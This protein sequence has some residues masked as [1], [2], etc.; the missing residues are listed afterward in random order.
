[1]G[2]N[3]FRLAGSYFVNLSL[4]KRTRLVGAQI[5]EFRA[6]ATNVT[7]HANWGVIPGAVSTASTFGRLRTPSG[8]N[9]RKVMLGVKYYF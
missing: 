3:A 7:N 5:L 8:N 2:R 9:S 6:D 4:A 1:T